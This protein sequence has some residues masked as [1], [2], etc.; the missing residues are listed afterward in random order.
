MERVTR[1]LRY[2]MWLGF[3][4]LEQI[5]WPNAR[6]VSATARKQVMW[7]I[8]LLAVGVP[9]NIYVFSGLGER[10]AIAA[11]AGNSPAPAML[12]ELSSDGHEGHN[13]GNAGKAEAPKET[14]LEHAQ[15]HADPKFVC[16]MHPEIV[17]DDP[18]ATCPICGMDL[19]PLENTGDADVVTLAPTVINA[20]GVRLD[21]VKRRTIYRRIES[22]GYITTNDNNLRTVSLRTEGWV[23]KLAIKTE[24]EKV[25]KG[26][27]IFQLYSPML[28]NTQEEYVQALE[29]DNGDGMLVEATRQRLRALGVSDIQIQ[30]LTDTREVEQLVSFYSPQDGFIAKLNISEGEFVPPSKSVVSIADLSTVWLMVD[31]FENQID[32]VKEGQGA[33]AR[34]SFMP[35]KVWEGEV[36]FVYPTLDAK[37]RSI[38]ARLRFD[39]PE[40]ILKPNMY[41]DISIFARPKRRALTVPREAVIRQGNQTRVI[42][43]Q[44]EG[45]FKPVIIHAGL[46]TDDR[47]EVIGGLEEDQEVVVSSQFL[48]DS[49][50]SMRAALMRMAGG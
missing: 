39:N 12:S 14:A 4:W 26:D 23:E 29:L 6:Q 24:G 27:L 1:S 20:L 10:Q 22:V 46:E 36:E 42:V 38:K 11:D 19:V 2:R 15:K 21:K 31:I 7:A 47:V 50:S 16:P 44:G 41:A 9:V 37:T 32:W 49:E 25:A 18:E 3:K 35:E 40:E 8:L 45:K 28:V 48:I 30:R 5:L 43:H 33:E 34:L 17:T 13:D